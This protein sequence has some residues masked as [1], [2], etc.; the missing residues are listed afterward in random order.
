[1]EKKRLYLFLGVF[2]FFFLLLTPLGLFNDWVSP[3][4][5]TG[6]YSV[7]ATD[8]GDD[9]GYYAYLRSAFFD[10]DFDFINELHYAH[11]E[12]FNPTGYVFNYWQI[13]QS[14]L[15]V[16]FFLV[17]HLLALLYNALGYPVSQD[18]YSAPYYFSTAVASATYVFAGLL[19]LFHIL[20]K[21]FQEPVAWITPF[22]LW[23]ASPL[24]YFTFIRQRMAHATEFCFSAIFLW[25]WLEYRKSE[26]ISD[27]ALIGA[28]LGFLCMIR[29]VGI[30]FLFLY[31]ADQAAQ[32]ISKSSSSSPRMNPVYRVF[33]FGVLALF[34]FL[35]QFF[36]WYGLDGNPFVYLLGA[37]EEMGGQSRGPALASTLGPK[38]YDFFFGPK[39]SLAFATPLWFLGL[40]GLF[41]LSPRPRKLFW[42]MFTF[43]S[44]LMLLVLFQ[45][46]PASYGMRYMIPATPVLAFGLAALLQKVSRPKWLFRTALGFVFLC[47]FVQYMMLV[48]YKTTLLY[49]DP[50]FTLNAVAGIPSIFTEKPGLLLRST[51]FFK[52]MILKGFAAW[53]YKDVLFLVVFPAFQI[54]ALIL[55]LAVWKKYPQEKLEKF[56]TPKILLSAFAVGILL[57]IALVGV[58]APAKSK[59]EIVARNTAKKLIQQSETATSKGKFDE[60]LL[61]L[62]KASQLVPEMWTPFF[63]MAIVYELKK[64]FPEANKNYQ[65]VLGVYPDHINTLLNLG[66]N[67]KSLGKFQEAEGYLKRAIRGAPT[68]TKGLNILAQVFARQNKLEEAGI[69]FQEAV[70][71]NP[72]YD[73]GRLNLVITLLSMGRTDEAEDQMAELVKSK[74][75]N[76]QILELM[77][78]LRYEFKRL[79][80]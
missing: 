33:S 41:F 69:L 63:R 78:K 2:Y 67:L 52:L 34:A 65:K 57:L 64:N 59:Q 71:I 28:V 39:W 47:V 21:Y 23:L 75:T 45:V 37:F 68:D 7:T 20:K 42:G 76:S 18:G 16:P 29:L 6:Y 31:L 32:W 13:G 10:G 44:V 58:L 38:I 73:I 49:N 36:T 56:V 61:L 26:K 46:E 11:I 40:L 51:N 50:G 43:L 25:T 19:V 15:F 62:N 1:M 9:A 55:V 12:R 53:D 60:S 24:L 77:D 27:H 22:S 54:A 74:P 17:G 8:E 72:R 79:Q 5:H 35:P 14:I 48:Q 3:S 30:C 4:L 66:D 70:K 80:K